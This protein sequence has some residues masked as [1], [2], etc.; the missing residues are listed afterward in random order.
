LMNFY[1]DFQPNTWHESCW[2]IITAYFDE[3]GL[4][5][6]QLESFDEFI[7]MSVQR[8]VEESP[9]IELQSE[10]NYNA[11]EPEEPTKYQIKFEQIYLS[12]V[13]TLTPFSFLK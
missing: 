3:K 7:T 13:N 9:V 8:I 11:G 5:R 6:Q 12:K 10:P 2:T 4:V 1:I